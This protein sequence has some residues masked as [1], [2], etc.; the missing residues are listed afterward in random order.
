MPNDLVQQTFLNAWSAPPASPGVLFHS[1]QCAQ[2]TP[3]PRGEPY[4]PFKPPAANQAQ[5]QRDQQAD[6]A[7]AQQQ[8]ARP[9][10]EQGGA[11][12]NGGTIQASERA[13][14]AFPES[15]QNRYLGS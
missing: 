11:P 6:P 14:G 2:Y 10:V 5:Q 9:R 4:N 1:K 15:P 12:I 8:P 13:M 7:K 3:A